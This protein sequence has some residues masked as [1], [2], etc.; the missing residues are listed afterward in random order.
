MIL[1]VSGA[2]GQAK[3]SFIEK[4][5]IFQL[6]Q[7]ETE[8]PQT[9][10]KSNKT[11]ETKKVTREWMTEEI[12]YKKKGS[13]KGGHRGGHRGKFPTA[14]APSLEKMMLIIENGEC[15]R[16]CRFGPSGRRK[17]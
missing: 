14:L 13:I 3:A 1:K 4:F 12:M 16:N 5:L 15:Q 6:Q 8:K 11:A 7:K 2:R 10:T 9:S 17:T